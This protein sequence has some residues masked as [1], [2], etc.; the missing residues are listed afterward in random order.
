MSVGVVFALAPALSHAAELPDATTALA[1]A[2]CAACHGL[3]GRGKEAMPSL[4][5]KSG[6][7]L[8]RKLHA[9]KSGSLAGTVMPQLARGYQDAELDALAEYFARLR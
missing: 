9:F 6:D 8:K 3:D 2:N 7:E 5:G 1:A 4:A